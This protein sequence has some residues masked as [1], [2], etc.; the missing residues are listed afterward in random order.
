MKI[1]TRTGDAGETGLF[2]GGRVGKDNN[3]VGAYGTVDELNAS[4]GWAVTQVVDAEIR[5]AQNVRAQQDAAA[6]APQ[7]PPQAVASPLV[8]AA[9]DMGGTVVSTEGLTD[10][11]VA[12]NVC[13]D[14]PDRQPRPSNYG[15]VYCTAKLAQPVQIT[16]PNGT[17]KISEFCTWKHKG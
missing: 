8:Q 6:I 11:G 1:Y 5:N 17:I 3:R 2:G 7:V 13:P 10:N 9:V 16:Q 4:I 15:G 14:H 12:P